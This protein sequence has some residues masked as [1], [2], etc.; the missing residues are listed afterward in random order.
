M[1]GAIDDAME[2]RLPKRVCQQLDAEYDKDAP[3]SAMIDLCILRLDATSCLLER[4]QIREHMKNGTLL[5]VHL[6]C[7]ASPVTGKE[8]QGMLIEY[9]TTDGI[10]CHSLPA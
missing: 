1:D 9:V 5:S 3:S 10:F 6:Y 2:A 8:I 4:E 7:D